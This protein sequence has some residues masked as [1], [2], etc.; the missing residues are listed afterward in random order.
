MTPP[1]N[2][3]TKK[4]LYIT[5]ALAVVAFALIFAVIMVATNTTPGES[6]IETRSKANAEAI[7]DQCK[8]ISSNMTLSNDKKTIDYEWGS[9]ASSA[10]IDA[11]DCLLEKS[12]A[13]DSVTSRMNHTRGLD[14]TQDAHWDGWEAYWNYHKS[15]GF[16]LTLTHS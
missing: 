16:N 12:G 2:I 10:S 1:R 3:S 7:Y 15:K 13:P 14:G 5:T 4:L 8:E 11:L 6:R 9:S